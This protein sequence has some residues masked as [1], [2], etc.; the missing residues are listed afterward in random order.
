MAPWMHR[1]T[2]FLDFCW[3]AAPGLSSEKKILTVTPRSFLDIE[4]LVFPCFLKQ[5][6]VFFFWRNE[7]SRNQNRRSFCG[8]FIPFYKELFWYPGHFAQISHD[9]VIQSDLFIPCW[10]SLNHLK[11]SLNHP[12]KV[13][14]NCQGGDDQS[15]KVV[16]LEPY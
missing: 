2:F 11:G 3:D 4:F 8:F 5:K 9:Q 13:T 15:K 16:M 1:K 7:I 12:K 6:D 10:R 14:K